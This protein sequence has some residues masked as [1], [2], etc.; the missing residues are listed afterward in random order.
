MAKK[1]RMRGDTPGGGR[2]RIACCKRASVCE[3]LVGCSTSYLASFVG[4]ALGAG[5]AKAGVESDP[6]CDE[7]V[8]SG[9]CVQ[10]L[11][12]LAASNRTVP[13]AMKTP[14]KPGARS[15]EELRAPEAARAQS[16]RPL[17]P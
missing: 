8:R 10:I 9:S 11:S 6:P 14:A 5:L 1:N 16:Q 4:A 2:G 17:T 15:R 12:L 7:C 3:G 13:L